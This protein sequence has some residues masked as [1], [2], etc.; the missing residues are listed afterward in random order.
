MHEVPV[1]IALGLVRQLTI[2][3]LLED[4]DALKKVVFQQ[5]GCEFDLDYRKA[6]SDALRKVGALREWITS[7]SLT[8]SG[9]EQLAWRHRLDCKVQESSEALA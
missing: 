6:A 2:N 3:R 7:R 9:I 1:R 4:A 5:A 8:Q